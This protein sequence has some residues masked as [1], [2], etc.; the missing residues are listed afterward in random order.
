V[1]E[2]FRV[3]EK[4]YE[5]RDDG[6]IVLKKLAPRDSQTL[7]LIRSDDGGYGG[8]HQRTMFKGTYVDVEIP[9]WK[10]LSSPTARTRIT[11]SARA[12]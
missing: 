3:F 11:S 6:K 8:A 4:V 1:I 7:F 2:G 10:T 12:R 5:V 9:A